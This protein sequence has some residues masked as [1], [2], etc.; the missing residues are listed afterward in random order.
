MHRHLYKVILKKPDFFKTLCNGLNNPL[1]F[2]C[3]KGYL[4]N[5]PPR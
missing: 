1:Q 4:Y 3:R 2:A 5:N